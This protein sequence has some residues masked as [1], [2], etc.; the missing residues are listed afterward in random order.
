VLFFPWDNGFVLHH[1][2]KF[3]FFNPTKKVMNIYMSE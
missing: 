1:Y 2:A 3:Q